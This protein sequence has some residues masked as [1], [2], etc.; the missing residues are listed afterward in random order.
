MPIETLK[1]I[2]AKSIVDKQ[3][4]VFSCDVGRDTDTESGIMQVGFYDFASIYGVNLTLS[5]AD[6]LN[7]LG[8]APTHAMIF[9]GVDIQND[10]PVK[11][12]VENSWGGHGAK[13]GC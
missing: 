11:W 5:K 9:I 12:L 13:T 3:P 7:T 4:V 2:V 8:G 1:S 10:K 6:R